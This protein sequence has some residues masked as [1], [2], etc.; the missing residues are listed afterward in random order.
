MTTIEE[1]TDGLSDEQL[2]EVPADEAPAGPAPDYEPCGHPLERGTCWFAQVADP[3][4]RECKWAI[5][6]DPAG[7]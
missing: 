7:R 6:Q 2:D 1:P 5:K 3:C 4:G